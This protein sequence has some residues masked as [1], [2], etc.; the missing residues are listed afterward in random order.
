[1]ERRQNL[2]APVSRTFLTLEA[3]TLDTA[4]SSDA[5]QPQEA[6]WDFR[7]GWAVDRG[8]NYFFSYL[9]TPVRKA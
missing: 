3:K 9:Q 1:M 5:A 6:I 2:L 4:Q 8:A 7:Y